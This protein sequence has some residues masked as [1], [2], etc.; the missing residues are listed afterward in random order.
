[1]ESPNSFKVNT[2][3]RTKGTRDIYGYSK[4][5]IQKQFYNCESDT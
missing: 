4:K 1:M 2:Q 3:S 5:N